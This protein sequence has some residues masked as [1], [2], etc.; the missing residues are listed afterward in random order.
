MTSAK[1][2]PTPS[3]HQSINPKPEFMEVRITKLDPRAVIPEYKTGLAAAFD[4]ATIEETVVPPLTQTNLRTGLGFGIPEGHAML[5]LSRSS[6]FKKFGVILA[7]GVG[8]IDAD[9]AGPTDEVHVAVINPKSTGLTIPA[10]TR[11]A[12]AMIIPRPRIEFIEG[13]P[14][15]R[16]RGSFGSTGY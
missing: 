16:D 3:I 4:L 7:N 8:I 1:R 12:Q 13:P 11:V 9:Y 10:G 2:T 15:E 6:T 14:G 5:I